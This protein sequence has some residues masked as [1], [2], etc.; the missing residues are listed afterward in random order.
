MDVYVSLALPQ[1]GARMAFHGQ[2]PLSA[3]GGIAG[4]A[5]VFLLGDHPFKLTS[6]S[7][8]TLKGTDRSYVEFDCSGF[9]G[10][11]LDAEIEFSTDLLVRESE[12][13]EPTDERLKIAFSVYTQSLH[14]IIS[15]ITLPPFQLKS[16]PGFGFHVTK[17]YL[18]WS[19]LSNPAGMVF[20]AG[21]TSPVLEARMD[22]LWQGI[23][24]Q[25]LEVRLPPAFAQRN[26][27]NRVAVGVQQMVIDEQGLTGKVFVKN[28][29][30]DG[31]MIGWAYTL[32]QVALDP[33][34]VLRSAQGAA[35][36]S[37]D[38]ARDRNRTRYS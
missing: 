23:Y 11:N 18:D 33:R 22:N 15:H 3:E 1:T 30:T 31:D 8:I 7:L 2:V 16:L 19:D 21:Y 4:N 34:A 5:K 17:A 13:G 35:I 12:R 28:I 27:D 32:D 25:E 26:T 37:R 6:T 14:D 36:G 10:I 24:L 29:I 20:P 38:R 9:L